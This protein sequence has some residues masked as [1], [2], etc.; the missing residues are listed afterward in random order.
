[1]TMFDQEDGRKME[2]GLDS[3]IGRFQIPVSSVNSMK[4]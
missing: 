3:L 1:M 4:R 2:D